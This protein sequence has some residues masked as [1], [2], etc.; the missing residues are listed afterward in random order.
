M[1]AS[2]IKALFLSGAAAGALGGAAVAQDQ[3]PIDE[4]GPVDP[5]PSQ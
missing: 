2:L 5:P 4:R 3:E 1:Q